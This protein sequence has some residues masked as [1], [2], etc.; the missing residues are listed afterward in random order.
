MALSETYRCEKCGYC[1]EAWD[2]G[3]PY[4]QLSFGRRH[5]FYHPEDV[6]SL[7]PLLEKEMGG[8]LT[9]EEFELALAER[10]GNAPDHLCPDCGKTFQLDPS[11]EQS[12]CPKCQSQRVFEIWSCQGKPCPKCGG[13]FLPGEMGAIS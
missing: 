13:R 6:Q 4:L 11:T 7:R 9:R 5:Y 1:V 3:N 2:D 8:I 10:I 12:V